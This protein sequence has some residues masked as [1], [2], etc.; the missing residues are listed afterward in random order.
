MI[1]EREDGAPRGA[2]EFVLRDPPF[3]DRTQTARRS[4][5]IEAASLFARLVQAGVRTIVF[6]RARRVAELSFCP[7]PG[8]SRRTKRPN[9]PVASGPTAP[10]TAPNNAGR[11][12]AG[13]ALA[14]ACW[15]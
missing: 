9:W 10:A 8:A 4:T 13:C 2:R 15:E 5:N 11:S 12:S 7:T 6:T 3:L 14:G 1:G